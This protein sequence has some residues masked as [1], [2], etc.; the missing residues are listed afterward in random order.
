MFQDFD[1]SVLI[2]LALPLRVH[3]CHSHHIPRFDE[4]SFSKN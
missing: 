3:S 2:L 1:D 4:R